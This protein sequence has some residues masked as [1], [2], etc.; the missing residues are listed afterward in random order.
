MDLRHLRYFVAVA[1]ELHFTRAA[2][3]LHIAQPPLSRQIRELEQELGVTL[4]HR[5]RH[6]IELSEAGRVFLDKARQILRAADSAIVEAQRAQRGESG[7]LAVGFFEQ[8]AYT[9]L[10]PI[11]R[12][13][14]QRYPDVDVQLRWFPVVDQVA[15]LMRGDVDIAFVRPVGELD[16]VSKTLLMK[17]A[18][19]A[20][21][22][23]DH[24]FATIDALSMK[25]CANER[26][27][28]YTAH[29]APDYHAGITRACAVAGFVPDDFIDVGQVYTALGLV[30]G[31]VG[32]AFVPS[33]V[34]RIRF[35]NVVYKPLRG[36]RLQ[37]EVY[38]AWTQRHPSALLNAFVDTSR[39]IVNTEF[40]G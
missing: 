20:V 5:T 9:L 17:E 34:Q 36:S 30:S 4:L 22:P 14:Q 25:H 10:P 18:F 23:A 35:D 13:F 39:H 3:R 40:A 11:L 2:K 19:V 28:N 15:A 6:Q 32:I 33:S 29:L 16:A 37:S 12:T 27:I 38:L 26:L 31:G 24:R 8:T 21:V 7:T 1:E